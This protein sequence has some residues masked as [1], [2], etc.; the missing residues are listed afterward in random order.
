MIKKFFRDLA[1]SVL[2]FGAVLWGFAQ[3]D[4]M[5][6]FGLRETII[7]EKIG[8]IYWD[9][10]ASNQ[11]FAEED[12]VCLPVDSL[13]TRLCTANGIDRE[14][15]GLHV[16][17]TDEVNAFAFPG[18]HLVV[19]T[20]LIAECYNQSELAGV[21]AHELA[22]LHKG[23]IMQKMVKELGMATLLTM[24]GANGSTEALA[25]IARVLTS[26]AY[27]RRLE[28]EADTTAVRYLQAA[29]I[30]PVGFSD[31]L[32]RLDKI[33]GWS[34][35]DA[36]ISTHPQSAVRA[37]TIRRLARETQP[38]PDYADVLHGFT[39]EDLQHAAAV[40][41]ANIGSDGF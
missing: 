2:T 6:L 15:I 3:V 28:Q 33:E 18:N 8:E 19:H 17:V 22:H 9:L 37:A 23:H 16:L 38:Q 32:E 39:W 24:A 31:F 34:A 27:D 13:L 36:W 4:W 5:S 29:G 25:E 35:I 14:P 26:T 21:L 40:L 1:L 10:F 11:T 12:A 30:D 41:T 7:E 20:A